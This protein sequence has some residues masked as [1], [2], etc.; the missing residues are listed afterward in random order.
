MIKKIKTIDLTSL[1]GTVMFIAFAIFLILVFVFK[2][3]WD[4]ESNILNKDQETILLVVFI[5]SMVFLGLA[6]VTTIVAGLLCIT[7]DW[8]NDY[9]NDKKKLYGWLNLILVTI[10]IPSNIFVRKLIKIIIRNEEV[11]YSKNLKINEDESNNVHKEFKIKEETIESSSKN[12]DF[13]LNEPFWFNNSWMYYDG[14]NYW[15]ANDKNEW[16]LT[17]KPTI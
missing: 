17:T 3:Q 13:P 14:I 7:T 8:Q 16:E 11:A 15:K 9:L 4:K 12:S 6:I 5:M 10:C 2:Q 1:L